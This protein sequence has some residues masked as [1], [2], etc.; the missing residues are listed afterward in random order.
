MLPYLE[1]TQV[2]N[3]INFHFGFNEFAEPRDGM[4]DPIARTAI[5]TTIASFICPS[6]NGKGRNSYRASNGTNWDWWSREAGA[7]PMTRNAD[8]KISNVTDGTSNTI[9]FGE[10]NRGDGDASRYNP[11][12]VYVGVPDSAWGIPTYVV[13]NPADYAV[14]QNSVIPDCVA[15]SKV[16][17]DGDLELG[18]VLLGRGRLP[19]RKDE[20]QPGAQQ[21]GPRLFAVGRHGR[22]DR[23]LLGP[24]PPSGRGQL[25]HDRRVG[26]VHQ[27]FDRHS[28]LVRAGDPLGRRGHLG[29]RLLIRSEG[30]G[31]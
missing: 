24:E 29:R 20:L 16:A 1:Q 5:Q 31:R 2:H 30:T 12:D 8:A 6:D 28:D 25:R 7:G 22:G 14:I 10:R 15:A 9:S 17:G 3:S 23:V 19:G 21:Q 11:G 26:Q 4:V 18:R 13:S 27:G